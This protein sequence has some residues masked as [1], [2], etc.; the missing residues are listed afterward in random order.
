MTQTLARNEKKED[1]GEHQKYGMRESG[2]RGQL[3]NQWGRD[4]GDY[5]NG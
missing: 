4:P 1:T 3:L 5:K 2:S